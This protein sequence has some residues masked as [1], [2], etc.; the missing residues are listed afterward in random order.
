[1]NFKKMVG[2]QVRVRALAQITAKSYFFADK[3]KLS[4]PSL[5]LSENA[6]RLATL[7]FYHLLQQVEKTDSVADEISKDSR[8]ERMDSVAA[9]C[10]DR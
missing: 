4:S 3:N 9:C 5:K 10:V 8:L 1:M 7:P 6:I 2:N